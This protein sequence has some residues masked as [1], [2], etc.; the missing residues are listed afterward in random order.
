MI[1]L[2][3]DHEFLEVQVIYREPDSRKYLGSQGEQF[4]E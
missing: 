4:L 2:Q 1:L 3:Y